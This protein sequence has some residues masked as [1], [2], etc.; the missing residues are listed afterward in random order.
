MAG[1]PNGIVRSEPGSGGYHAVAI[2]KCE[3]RSSIGRGKEPRRKTMSWRN[4]R[5]GM[6]VGAAALLAWSISPQLRSQEPPLR[7]ATVLASA[8]FYRDVLPI[9]QSHCQ[10]CHRAGGIAPMAFEQF[11]Q[12]KPFADAIRTATRQKS[13]PP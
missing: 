10:E 5:T 6:A 13:M 7:T 9:L 8:T 11:E 3:R 4:S 12:S 2:G 1:V